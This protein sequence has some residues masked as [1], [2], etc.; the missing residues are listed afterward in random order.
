MM[1]GWWYGGVKI[2]VR[3]RM[4][5]DV[6]WDEIIYVLD[7]KFVYDHVYGMITWYLCFVFNWDGYVIFIELW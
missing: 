5:V 1:Y 7:E 6:W 2:F 3:S 4:N